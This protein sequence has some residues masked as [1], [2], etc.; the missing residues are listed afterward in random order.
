MSATISLS[1]LISPWLSL[2]EPA[3]S[4]LP[5]TTLQLDSRRIRPGDIFIA[6]IGHQVDGRQ[7]ITA[8]IER[9]AGAVLAQ[10]DEEHPH[11]QISDQDGVP[12]IYIQDLNQHLSQLAGRLYSHRGNQVIGVTGTNGKTTITQLIAQWLTLL[13]KRAAVMGTTGNGFLDNLQPAANTTGS[14]IDVQSCLHELTQQ[15]AQYTALEVSSHGLVQQR[16]NALE[17][18]VGIFSNLS[19]DHLDYHGDMESYAQAKLSLFTQHIC[20]HSVLNIDDP[21]GLSWAKMLP[22]AIPVSLQHPV[23]G[24]QGIYADNVI[25]SERGIT[26]EI[27]GHRIG[28]HTLCAPLIGEFN[29]SNLLLAFTGLICLG[30]SPESLIE[31]APHLQPVLG[32]MELFQAPESAKVVIDYAHTPDALEKALQAL[33]VHCKGKLWAILGCGGDRDRGKRPM[34]A[35]IAERLA[36][37][38]ILT[39]DNPRSESPQMIIED[40]LAGMKEPQKAF[41][42]HSRFKSLQYALKHAVSDDIIL[43]AGKG[44]EDYQIIGSETIHYSDRETAQTLLGLLP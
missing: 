41:V 30:F 21:V 31:T 32:R 8:A 22:N 28:S 38:V 34:M 5:V 14:A 18:S 17:F 20:Q 29:A 25:Y 19:R 27:N 44:H 39:D 1:W 42:E 7:F 11:A 23:D 3:L 13:G 4:E 9:G 40:M 10:A 12:I 43:L 24:L 35:E 16:V 15:G 36:D 26:I 2:D 6:I 33:R 37:A